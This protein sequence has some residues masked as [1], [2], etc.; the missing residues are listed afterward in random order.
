[1]AE[2]ASARNSAGSVR[3]C[4]KA[5]SLHASLTTEVRSPC[6]LVGVSAMHADAIEVSARV[7]RFAPEE[8]RAVARAFE[9]KKLSADFFD[10]PFC[11]YHALRE[12]DP[13]RRMADGAYLLTRYADCEAVYKDARTF[14]SDKKVEFKPKYG[15][16]PLFEHHTTS[17]VFNDPPLHTHVRRAIMAA[18]SPRAI[19]EMEP[20]LVAL[21]DRLIDA[22][23]EKERVDLIEDFAA[24]IP[25][26]VIGN[27]LGVPRAERGPLRGW[28]LAILGALEPVLTE[29]QLARGNAAVI[30]FVAYLE[31][32]VAERRHKPGDPERDVLTRLIAG[33][34]DGR[35][36]TESE[37]LQNC[38]FILN[39]GHET[40]TNLIGNALHAL[41]LWPQERRRLI[42]HP[43]LAKTG[44]EEVLRF[45]SSN[46]LG[47]RIT[48]V[49]T[50]LGGVT[51]PAG[52]LVT[53]GI[54]AANRD[55]AQFPDPDRFDIS[56]TPNR[57]LAFATGIHQCAGMALAR[58]EGR[59][60]LE[61]FL[62][63][64]PDYRLD[65]D[66]VRSRRARFRGF[67]E[68]PAT[69]T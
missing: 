65:G 43:D 6:V 34:H 22:M 36:L 28:S 12:H 37:L 55:P 52:T 7:R 10:D 32:L 53:I 69:L 4:G 44:V 19:A 11:Y 60:A 64:F 57:H 67:T 16:S 63:R 54:G 1:M 39:A 15:D 29:E 41:A 30:D 23:A 31:V 14:S 33:E 45:E 49:D 17:L 50:V 25:V 3:I 58:L 62:A 42:E 5:A 40:T 68:L 66:P 61:R 47:N 9:L 56:R 59:I 35:K 20:S 51:M 18:L 48:T 21:V 26:E 24:A 2:L 13:V 27:L 38:I 46:Q 8:A